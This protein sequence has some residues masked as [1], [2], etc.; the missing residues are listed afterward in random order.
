MTGLGW[1]YWLA[2]DFPVLGKSRWVIWTGAPGAIYEYRYRDKAWVADNRLFGIYVGS[3][4][5]TG[6]TEAQARGII[7][8]FGGTWVLPEGAPGT[9]RHQEIE[10]QMIA[11][12]RA[13]E[14]PPGAELM[15]DIGTVVPY[16]LA[17]RDRGESHSVLWTGGNGVRIRRFDYESDEWVL[18][19]EIRCTYLGTSETRP[20]TE[21]EA[22]ETIESNGGTWVALVPEGW[23]PRAKGRSSAA[24]R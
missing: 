11:N 13:I 22:K 18:D 5:T 15:E 19:P 8:Y 12:T 24:S 6:L 4:L 23:H 21:Q 1:D 7:E 20:L 17:S 16:W 10:A 9:P 2:G 3:P 14:T